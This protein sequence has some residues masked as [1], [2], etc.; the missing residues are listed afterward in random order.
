MRAFVT[1]A[2][3]FIGQVLCGQLSERGH[4]VSALV[5]RPGSEPVGTKAVRGDL[6]EEQG[7]AEA[8]ASERP[9]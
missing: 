6:R 1:G 3:G 5:R 9:D 7:I 4:D 8:L 2:S